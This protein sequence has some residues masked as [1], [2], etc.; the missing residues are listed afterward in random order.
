MATLE[1]QIN[2]RAFP[3]EQA[4]LEHVRVRGI[5][6]NISLPAI[7]RYLYGEDVDATRTPREHS[8]RRKGREEDDSRA[9][10]KERR[11]MEA[12]RRASIA[13]E[14]ACHIR[15][16]ESAAGA[17]SSRDVKIAGGTT[18]SAVADE[19]TTEGFQTT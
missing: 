10:K 19:D 12:A 9:R 5:Q 15:V 8:K 7:R 6:V 4:P 18:D 17:Y 14:E 16:V 13:D 1:S 2:R 11:D 3:I